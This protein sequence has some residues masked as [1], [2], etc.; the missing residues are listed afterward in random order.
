MNE[1]ER[2]FVEYWETHREKEGDFMYQLLTGLPIGLLF[3]LPIAILLFSARYWF[4]RADMVANSRL[5]PWLLGGAILLIATFVAVLYKRQRWDMKEQ[6]YKR[7]KSREIK[8]GAE[9][10]GKQR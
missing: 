9:G 3:S 5:N 10:N 1:R 7:L 2:L 4:L 8:G 6:Q